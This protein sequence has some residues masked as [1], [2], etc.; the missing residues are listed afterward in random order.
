MKEGVLDI[1]IYLFENYFDAESDAAT[2]ARI[3]DSI[4]AAR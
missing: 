4:T 2:A 3:A 1:L